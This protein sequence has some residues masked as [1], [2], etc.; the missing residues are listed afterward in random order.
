MKT[1]YKIGAATAL[2]T[3]LFASGAFAGNLAE[4]V[5][6][7][8]ITPVYSPA[9]TGEWTGFYSGLN[10]GYA[11]IDGDGAVD[12]NDTSYGIHLGYDYDFG[13]FVL[14]GELEYDKAD[15]D[16]NGLANAD[17]I[18]RLKIRGGY[19]LGRTMIYATAGAAR[20]DTN[21]GKDT[22]EFIGVGVA[23]QVTDR[24]TVGGELL[25]HRFD[26]IGGTAL[27]AD[28]TTFNLRGSYRF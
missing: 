23:Y 18:A 1:L 13:K 20:L 12:G 11:D 17:S 6:E 22:G 19:D 10:L 15:V 14:G 5:V 28:A 25:E 16:L 24:F 7:P 26:D 3:S 27:D 8:V 9:P 2:S 21:V 4:P